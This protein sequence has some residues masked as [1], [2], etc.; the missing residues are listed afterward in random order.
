MISLPP[1]PFPASNSHGI[2]AGTRFHRVHDQRFDS[3]A[4]NPEKGRPSRFAPLF[5]SG[6]PIPT[7]YL[8][9]NFEC[10]AHE[11]IF[12]DIPIDEP[13]KTVGADNIKPLAHSVVEIKRDIVLVPLFAPDLAKWGIT[14]A[15]LIDTTGASYDTTAAWALAIH[16]RRPDASGLIWTSKRCDP[17]QALLL[18]GDRVFESDLSAINKISIYGQIDEMR[19]II[20]F[21][22][23]ADITIVL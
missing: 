14:R 13:N 6:K 10:A 16:Q 21:A 15:D 22:G 11:T 18:F 8:A 19:Q 7:L 4:F 20:G 2:K 23:R 5:L 12:H 3:C 9:T 1:S 17:Q